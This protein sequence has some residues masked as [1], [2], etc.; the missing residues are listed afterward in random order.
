MVG[1]AKHGRAFHGPQIANIL[2]NAKKA[3]ITLR[4]AADATD[5]GISQIAAFGAVAD[6]ARHTAKFL[7]KGQHEPVPVLQQIQRGA[8]GRPRPQTGKACKTLDQRFKLRVHIR[9]AATCLAAA[10]GRQ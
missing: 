2:D 5:I 3:A 4:I 9:K 6:G 10:A 1:A 7:G 8:A